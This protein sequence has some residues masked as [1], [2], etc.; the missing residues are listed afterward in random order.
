MRFSARSVAAEAALLALVALP[1]QAQ[2]PA[3][4]VTGSITT[5]IEGT[6]VDSAATFPLASLARLG[7][8]VASAAGEA[9]AVLDTDTI[10][11]WTTS[12]FFRAGARVHQL[13]TPISVVGGA[14][15]VP[16]QFFIQ[17]LPTAYPDRFEFRGGALVV[18]GAV[19]AP[20]PPRPAPTQHTRVVIID[21]GHGGRDPGKIGPNGLR[22]KDVTLS[23]AQRLGAVLRQRG[24]EV[25][26]TRTTDTL[27]ALADRPALANRWR[28]DRPVAVF[29]SIHA[30]SFTAASA[31]GFETFFLSEARTEDERRVAEMENE[32]VRF[33]DGPTHAPS[34]GLEQILNNL[35]SDFL[36]RASN[37]LATITQQ[38]LAAFHPGPDRGVKRAGFLVLVGAIMPAVLIETAFISNRDEAALLAAQSFQEK[39]VWGIADAVDEFFRR[40]EHLWVSGR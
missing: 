8:R 12:P 33:E 28:G 5:T 14:L 22:E 31:R 37:D 3:L 4:R 30:N 19:V 9:T 1:L 25:H 39:I 2:R 36:L 15:H 32:A 13:A 29:L 21:A 20:A 18:K 10:R 40:N 11:F 34:S 27:I 7:F 26:L 6:R 38:K 17:W 16:E 35:R 24:Y 23:I